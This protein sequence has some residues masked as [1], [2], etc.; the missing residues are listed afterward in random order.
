MTRLLQIEF[1]KIWKNRA[2]RILTIAY[3]AD[4]DKFPAFRKEFTDYLIHENKMPEEIQQELNV[5]L[6]TISKK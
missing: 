3:L 1:Q 2:S 4:K 6:D 5:Y